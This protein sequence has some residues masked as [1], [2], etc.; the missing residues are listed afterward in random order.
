MIVAHYKTGALYRVLFETAETLEGND[1]AF[2]NPGR[3]AP[4][5]LWAIIATNDDA[6]RGQEVAIRVRIYNDGSAALY[7]IET[8]YIGIVYVAL[9]D[10]RIYF[11]RKSEFYEKVPDKF[12]FC[13]RKVNAVQEPHVQNKECINWKQ[14]ELYVPRFKEVRL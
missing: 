9:A 14:R 4:F 12:G 10:G 2:G 1:R 6:R 11:R 3:R 7:A 8:N 5:V 13:D